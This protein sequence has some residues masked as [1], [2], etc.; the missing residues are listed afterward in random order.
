MAV[1]PAR[2]YIIAVAQRVYIETGQKWA[3]AVS[4]D[5]PGW[6]RRGRSP[7]DAIEQLRLYAPR[8]EL[9]VDT[10]VEAHDIDVVGSVKGTTTT[11]FGAP[12][13]WGPWDEPPLPVELRR[14]HVQI[15]RRCWGYFDSVIQ[16]A[17]L[18]LIKGPRGGGRDRDKVRAHTREAERAYASKI[19]LRIA[20]RTPW[21][22][23]RDLLA[24]RLE[25]E[26][27]G[28]KWPLDYALRRIAWHVVDHAW[29]VLDKTP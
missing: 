9:I 29:E 25:S 22:Q 18:E 20:P 27:R 10:H 5:W 2:D 21:E 15:L 16:G 6:C 11:D 12:D 7:D 26:D 3:F 14:P 24:Q 4:L 19:G 1:T 23:Q 13:S 28:E 17:P 8:Y